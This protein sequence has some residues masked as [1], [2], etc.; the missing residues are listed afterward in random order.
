MRFRC[1]FGI[2]EWAHLGYVIIPGAGSSKSHRIW[3]Y[4]TSCGKRW[5]S[6]RRDNIPPDV[7]CHGDGTYTDHS[8]PKET[9]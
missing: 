9:R 1:R 7:T 6:G 8:R 3:R 4:C 5:T 2:H